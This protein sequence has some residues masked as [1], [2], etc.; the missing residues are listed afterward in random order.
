MLTTSSRFSWLNM[1]LEKHHSSVGEKTND[2][3]SSPPP[4]RRTKDETPPYRVESVSPLPRGSEQVERQGEEVVV[5]QP[6]V[7]A[8]EAH[9][10][11][12]VARSVPGG[13]HREG[14]GR[15]MA[16]KRDRIE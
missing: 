3:C 2:P 1:N 11:D 14:V 4:P 13:E 7:H 5:D 9:H 6:G 15:Q 16:A 8:E 10:S 12:H